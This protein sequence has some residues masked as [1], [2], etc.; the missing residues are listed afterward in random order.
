MKVNAEMYEYTIMSSLVRVGVPE[1]AVV[2]GELLRSQGWQG[3]GRKTRLI[4]G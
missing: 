1:L 3:L 2:M 4:L